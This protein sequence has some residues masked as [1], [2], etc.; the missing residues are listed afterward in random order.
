[1]DAAALPRHERTLAGLLS[2]APGA[3]LPLLGA[4]EAVALR[5]VC[6][7]AQE[8]CAEHTWPHVTFSVRRRVDLWRAAFPRA[9][10]VRLVNVTDSAA[11]VHLRGIHTLDMRW[12][13]RI[14]DA[15]F[16]NLR[17]IYSLNMSWCA[18]PTIT[19]A[20]FAALVGIH[21]LDMSWCKQPTI[22]DAAFANLH[23]INRLVVRGCRQDVVAGAALLGA[24]SE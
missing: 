16:A 8:A 3:L 14:T 5:S 17:G 22:S 6:R 9:L 12:C 19:D 15:A 23:G 18:Q 21:T 1:M 7:V 20:A 10:A 24:I 4:A 13:N 2:A 11:F